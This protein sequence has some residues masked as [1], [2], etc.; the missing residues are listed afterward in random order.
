MEVKYNDHL[1]VTRLEDGVFDIV[2]KN[3][4][5]IAADRR[6]A[7]TCAGTRETIHILAHHSHLF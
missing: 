2:V 1:A 6:E 7:E 4:H 3:V 5:F